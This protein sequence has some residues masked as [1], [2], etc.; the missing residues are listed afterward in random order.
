MAKML[1]TVLTPLEA[2]SAVW[3]KIKAHVE[4]RLAKQ[5]ERNDRSQPIE[6][7]EYLRG[8]IAELKYLAALDQPAPQTEADDAFR[9]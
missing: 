6:K 2:Q 9:D 7:T 5:R 3:K 1:E 4:A 8:A